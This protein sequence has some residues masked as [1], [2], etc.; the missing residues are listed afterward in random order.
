MKLHGSLFVDSEDEVGVG[1]GDLG[2]VVRIGTVSIHFRTKLKF[3]ELWDH[4]EAYQWVPEDDS[5]LDSAAEACR[6][7][8]RMPA[9]SEV[10][11]VHY[12]TM[13]RGGSQCQKCGERIMAQARGDK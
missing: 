12:F 7:V 8:G 5:E 4:M 10:E 2:P 1:D 9:E 13:I 6:E 11:C 3:L